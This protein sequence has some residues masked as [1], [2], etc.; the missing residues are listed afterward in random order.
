MNRTQGVNFCSF[1]KTTP[2]SSSVPLCLIGGLL[3]WCFIEKLQQREIFKES[4]SGLPYLGNLITLH[5]LK[6]IEVHIANRKLYIEKHNEANTHPT[7]LFPSRDLSVVFRPVISCN[8]TTPKEYT[9]VLVETFPHSAYSG[10]KYPRVPTTL[11]SE[12]YSESSW[13]VFARPKSPS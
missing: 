9:S 8:R 6:D 13:R 2:S 1:M 4:V 3:S 10:A 7:R 5:L 12:L 11:V